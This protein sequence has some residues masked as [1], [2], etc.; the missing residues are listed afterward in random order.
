MLALGRKKNETIIIDGEI[1]ITVLDISGEQVKLGIK[2]PKHISIYRKEIYM[3]IQ[4]EN[5]KSAKENSR[6]AINKFINLKKD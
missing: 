4:Q 5:K 3:Q 2:A 1:E 6:T